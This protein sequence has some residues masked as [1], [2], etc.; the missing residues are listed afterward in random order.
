MKMVRQSAAV[1]ALGLALLLTACSPGTAGGA[2][3]TGTSGGAA[4]GAS[5]A[6]SLRVNNATTYSRNFNIYSPSTDIAPQASL[7]Y[8]PLV[9]R[10]V[11]KGGQ[12]EP[13]LAESWEWS[14]GDKTVT[15]KLRTDVKFSDGTPMTSKDVAFTLNIPLKYPELNTGG[16]TYVSAEATDEHTVVVTWKKPGQLDFYRFAL[17]AT[18]NAPR[19]VPEHL[20]KDQDL[21]TWTNPDPVGTGVGKLTQFTPQQFTLETR[22]DYWGGQF[23]MKAIKIVAAG[24]DDQTKARLLKGDLDFATMSWPNA[25][26]EYMARNPQANVYRTFHTG[27]EESLLFNLDKEPFADAGVRKALAMSVD[28]SSLL[29]LA[30]TG[31]EPANACGLEPQVYADFMAP[32]CKPQALDVEGAK[33]ALADG[34]W[35]VEGGLLSKGGKTY[36]L[37]VKVVQEYSNWMAWGKGMQ[38]QWKTNLGLD[39]KVVATPEENYDPQLNEGDFDMALY[40]TGGSN[41]LY[42]VFTDQLDPETYVPVGKDAQYQNQGRWKDQSTAP[43]LDTIRT[44]VGDPAKQKE[45]GHQLQKILL[46]QVPYSPMFTADWFIEMNNARWTGWPEADAASHVPHSALGPD[47]ILTLKN[48]KPAGQ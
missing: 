34:G 5:D 7:I 18:S 9:R 27:G 24:G 3:Q 20:W 33:K 32:E 26:Q 42:S 10:N 21:K 14:D 13:W 44:N 22:A 12:L 11:F 45:A 39:V 36:P 41:G 43:L 15:I 40:W 16:Q 2:P 37:S 23:P 46:E 6:I 47:F 4:A 1:G 30:P 31:Q 25:E 38:D 28:R 35:T 17:G 29:K 8:E 19:I 48:L